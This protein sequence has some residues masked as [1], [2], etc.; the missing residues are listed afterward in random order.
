MI[1]TL[2]SQERN[3]GI[4]TLTD[5]LIEK[6]GKSHINIFGFNYLNLESFDRVINAAIQDPT[7]LILVKYVTPRERFSN[8][9]VSIPEEMTLKSDLIF[10]VPTYLEEISRNAPLLFYKGEDNYIAEHIKKFY[11]K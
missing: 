6:V 4:L 1:V 2:I 11:S 3:L 8:Q 9:G 5:Y 10:K 7:K